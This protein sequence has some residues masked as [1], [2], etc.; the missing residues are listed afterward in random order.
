MKYNQV[1]AAKKAE[2]AKKTEESKSLWKKIK[3]NK[4]QTVILG[5]AAYKVG[6]SVY[7]EHIKKDA[8]AKKKWAD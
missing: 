2:P 6:E 4:V 7:N 1:L 8:P 5:V 3:D